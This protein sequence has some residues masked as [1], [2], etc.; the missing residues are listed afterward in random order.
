MQSRDRLDQ[1]DF[2]LDRLVGA[3]LTLAE[4]VNLIKD[5][6]SHLKG[7]VQQQV[8]MTQEQTAW[9]G[10]LKAVCQQQAETAR[11]QA[12]TV[13]RLIAHLSPAQDLKP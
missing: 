7:I 3:V 1:I 11:R 5:D 13:E 12:E 10:E 9:L 4:A 2:R 6:L 8:L